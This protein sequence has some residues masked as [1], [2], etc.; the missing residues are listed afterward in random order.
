M[1]PA[2]RGRRESSIPTRGQRLVQRVC[3]SRLSA[4]PPRWPLCVGCAPA[5][6]RRAQRVQAGGLGARS[7]GTAGATDR[8]RRRADHQHDLALRRR[9]RVA[10]GQLGGGA[11]ARPPRAPSSA[12]GRRPP[13]ASGSS[14]ASS[15][16]VAGRRRGDSNATSVSAAR[17]SSLSQLA[18]LARQ[19][20]EEVPLVRGQARRHERGDR[21]RGARQHLH[22]QP[23]G[24][25]A[26]HQHVSRGRTPAACRRPRPAP[27]PR[28]RASARTSSADARPLVVL[29][30]ARRASP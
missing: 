17:A 19:E 7:A 13:R 5:S 12:R 22:R 20:P 30:V 24:H 8:R 25:A 21:R 28:R 16:S 4:P 29:V 23:R 10:L 2:A 14:S 11:R 18:L 27:P 6:T 3:A 15:A 9:A 26:A 1:R